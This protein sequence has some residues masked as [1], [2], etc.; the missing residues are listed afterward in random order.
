MVWVLWV[1]RQL[2]LEV[3]NLLGDGIALAAKQLLTLD[4]QPGAP[5]HTVAACFRSRRERVAALVVRAHVGCFVKA[6]HLGAG[7][8]GGGL[9]GIFGVLRVELVGH[10]IG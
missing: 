3:G 7:S 6:V 8:L 10:A 1:F 4:E 2:R 9:L 5:R